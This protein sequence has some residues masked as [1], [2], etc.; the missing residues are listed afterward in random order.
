MRHGISGRKFSRTKNQRKALL[1]SL[2]TSLIKNEKIT[3]TIQ[4]AKDLRPFIEKIVTY[5][6]KKTLAVRRRLRTVPLCDEACKK[7][8]H[9]LGPRYKERPGGYTRIIKIGQRYG[10][11]ASM[12]II[13]FVK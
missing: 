5:A 10:D 4:K 3:T 11:N 8:Y 6:G 7:L 2:A 13:E 9:E 1:S 12:A